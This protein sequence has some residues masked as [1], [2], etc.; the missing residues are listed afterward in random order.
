MS[1]VDV[2]GVTLRIM[3][4][5]FRRILHN[6]GYSFHPSYS[7]LRM[8]RQPPLKILSRSTYDCGNKVRRSSGSHAFLKQPLGSVPDAHHQPTS[9]HA[10]SYLHP[11]SCHSFSTLSSPLLSGHSRWSKI[12]HD[13]A[14]VDSTKNKARSTLSREITLASKRN[15]PPCAPSFSLS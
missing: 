14:K 11:L 12:K 7:K 4:S 1:N 13:K 3:R 2:T 6:L 8:T 9:Q 5:T 10:S 15:S